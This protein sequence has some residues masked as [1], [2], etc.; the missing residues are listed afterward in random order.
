MDA[1]P[2]VEAPVVSLQVRSLALSKLG[3]SVSVPVDGVA[4]GVGVVV[5]VGVAVAVDVT[6]GV[7]V[8]VGVEVIVGVA[9]GVAVGPGVGV[10]V[11]VGEG[12]GVFVIVGVAVAVGVEGP[13]GQGTGIAWFTEMTPSF[14]A[15][16]LRV[17]FSWVKPGSSVRRWKNELPAEMLP[18]PRK[19]GPCVVR[20]MAT[21]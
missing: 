10:I 16:V 15:T 13:G 6:V 20:S 9:V 5:G 21:S 1:V 3:S 12:P 19:E 2:Q 14:R 8:T 7:A 18:P 4:V 11:G 17:T